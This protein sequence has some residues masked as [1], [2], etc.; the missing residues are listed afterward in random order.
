VLCDSCNQDTS[1]AEKLDER[2]YI[3][4][5]LSLKYGLNIKEL[6]T[7]RETIQNDINRYDDNHKLL[8]QLKK[9]HQSTLREY[10]AAAQMLTQTRERTAV[11]FERQISS[12]LSELGMDKAE[13]SVCFDEP[14]HADKPVLPKLTGDDAIEFLFTS[15]SGE[16]LKPLAKIASGGEVSRVM[17]AIKAISTQIIGTPCMVFDEVDTGISGKV[18]QAVAER[19]ARIAQFKQVICVTHLP[20]IAAMADYHYLVEKH[21]DSERSF[22]SVR[23]LNDAERAYDIARIITGADS[24]EQSALSHAKSML[25]AAFDYKSKIEYSSNQYS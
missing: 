2:L 22:T 25:N 20:Q 16:P 6:I 7:Y 14:P 18:A 4:K 12:E 19:M 15:N 24:N 3:I 8:E 5:R 17:L 10:R 21:D 9:I 13:L 23:R 11:L 1:N